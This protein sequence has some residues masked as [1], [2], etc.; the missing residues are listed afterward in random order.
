MIAGHLANMSPE[1]LVFQP[2]THA[3]NKLPTYQKADR[4]A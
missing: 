2:G 4:Q 1:P 3:T